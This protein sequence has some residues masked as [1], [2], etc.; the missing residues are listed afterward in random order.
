MGEVKLGTPRDRTV[1]RDISTMGQDLARKETRLEERTSDLRA[2]LAEKLAA[3]R[4]DVQELHNLSE[5]AKK[6]SGSLDEGIKELYVAKWDLLNREPLPTS[7][8]ADLQKNAED[9]RLAEWSVRS[10]EQRAASGEKVDEKL[11]QAKAKLEKLNAKTEELGKKVGAA[12]D[13]IS[14]ARK[15]K[16]KLEEKVEKAQTAL[17]GVE[18]EM[19]AKKE[20]VH[21]LRGEIILL[22]QRIGEKVDDIR[23]I[24]VTLTWL[25][26]QEQARRERTKIQASQIG[27][28]KR[29]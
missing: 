28:L 7:F 23:S 11:G 8:T 26:S 19:S 6:I 5:K 14:S 13:E 1:V 24:D 20:R 9:I 15:K 25:E 16:E 3:F 18:A 2:S 4:K 17:A 29:A 22:E 27:E 21:S 12:G 10:L